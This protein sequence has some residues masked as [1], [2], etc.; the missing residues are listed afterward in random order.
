M[1]EKAVQTLHVVGF[2][3]MG[4]SAAS[5]ERPLQWE[6]RR[7]MQ[8]PREESPLAR[9]SPAEGSKHTKIKC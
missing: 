1:V 2:R 7:L 9:K 8:R 6:R 3:Q 4:G 5:Q